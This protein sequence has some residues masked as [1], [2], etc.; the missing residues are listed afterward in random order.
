MTHKDALITAPHSHCHSQ[1]L[2][3]FYSL[4]TV[5]KPLAI[6]LGEYVPQ[7]QL[8]KTECKQ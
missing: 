4:P 2:A 3:A 1:P 8:N 5:E 7:D 6:Y